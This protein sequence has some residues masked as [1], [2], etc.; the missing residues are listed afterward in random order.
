MP[1]MDGLTA[2]KAIRAGQAGE[3]AR[4]LW[5]IALSA[6]AREQQRA[7]AMA[8]GLND[9]LT[10]PL[11]LDELDAVFRRLQAQRAARNG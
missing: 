4:A 6:D 7:E 1:V 3:A 2:L 5:I 11:D 8:A 10:K 9:Y